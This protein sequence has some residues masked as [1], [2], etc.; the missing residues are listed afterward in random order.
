M[1]FLGVGPPPSL[2][3]R[4]HAM[5]QGDH[6]SRD[7]LVVRSWFPMPSLASDHRR[8]ELSPSRHRAGRLFKSRR[9]SFCAHGA[10]CHY[11]ASGC[12]CR[13]ALAVHIGRLYRSRHRAGRSPS[14]VETRCLRSRCSMPLF[15]V[16]TPPTLYALAVHIGR[17]YRS[18][19]RAGRDRSSR[20]ALVVRSW[21][22]MPFFGVGPPP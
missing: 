14:V 16:G 19:N 4:R 15:G 1:P 12:R 5:V 3:S 18:R 22:S 21:F 10:R 7:A 13:C 6:S 20:D 8:A 11:L 2:R 17:L 9:A